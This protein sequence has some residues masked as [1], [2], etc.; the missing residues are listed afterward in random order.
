MYI[1][2]SGIFFRQCLTEPGIP[3]L[4]WAA[5]LSDQPVSSQDEIVSTSL[6]WCHRSIL[7][8][9]GHL[10][11]TANLLTSEPSPRPWGLFI[12]TL[13]PFISPNATLYQHHVTVRFQ[14]VSLSGSGDGVWG[15]HRSIQIAPFNK[16]QVGDSE[17]LHVS[18][19]ASRSLWCAAGFSSTVQINFIP[20]HLATL[21]SC[22]SKSCGKNR[23]PKAQP[24]LGESTRFRLWLCSL[25][26]KW[27][28]QFRQ[29]E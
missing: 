29:W 14:Q 19:T 6:C 23:F 4:G 3:H 16:V 9:I 25:C 26:C 22:C 27:Q 21:R 20:P 10:N 13:V 8:G 7:Y 28:G 11:C 15:A 2:S 5:W 12:R 1:I 17:T 18:L 24:L